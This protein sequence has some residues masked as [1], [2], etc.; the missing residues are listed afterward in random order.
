MRRK[1]KDGAG[2][3]VKDPTYSIIK[4]MLDLSVGKVIGVERPTIKGLGV[5]CDE[6]VP[7]NPLDASP[8]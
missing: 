8:V 3:G 2:P 6:G 7:S 4:A 5:R 1:M